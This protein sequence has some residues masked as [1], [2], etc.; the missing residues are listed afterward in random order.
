MVNIHAGFGWNRE[1]KW[2]A[3]GERN[4]EIINMEDLR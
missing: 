1:G 2:G 4:E 3:E